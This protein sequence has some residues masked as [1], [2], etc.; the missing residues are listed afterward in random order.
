VG[1]TNFSK[2]RNV[3]RPTTDEAVAALEL[4]ETWQSR[5]QAR[6]GTRFV[7][8]SDELYL[9]AGRTE[10]PEADAY[11]GFP[12]LTNGVGMLRSMVDEWAKLLR[13]RRQWPAERGVAWLSAPLAAPALEQM[14]RLWGEAAGWTP[15]VV[16][17]ENTLFGEQ[18]TV[19]GL[20]S[21]HDLIRALRALPPD[22]DD[23]VLPRTA[24]GF[25]GRE[26]LDGVP[27]EEIGAAHPGRVHLASTPA[28]LLE[29]FSRFRPR[30]KPARAV[31]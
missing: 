11:D 24:F 8:P 2:V 25:D 4:C 12:V 3:R 29:I 28:E 21:G 17:V 30:R 27:A 9:L 5:L 16:R 23:V 1:L 18:V 7:Y 13:R 22:L 20:L 26:T 14:A 15:R 10:L 19:S 31:A 6:F